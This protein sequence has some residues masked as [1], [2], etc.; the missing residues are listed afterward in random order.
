MNGLKTENGILRWS[1]VSWDK[2]FIDTRKYYPDRGY[3]EAAEER[4]AAKYFSEEESR[5]SITSAQKKGKVTDCGYDAFACCYTAL[6]A[7]RDIQ[8]RADLRITAVPESGV[9]N[10]QE[11]FGI[12]FRDTMDKDPE[13]GHGLR[14]RKVRCW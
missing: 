1:D 2:R 13:T 5:L 3:D 12:F 8:I 7:D 4:K 9:L 14:N 6:P 10:D 11:A